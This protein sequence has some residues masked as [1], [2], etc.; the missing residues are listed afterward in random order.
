MRG[1]LF[2]SATVSCFPRRFKNYRPARAACISA[3]H[4]NQAGKKTSYFPRPLPKNMVLHHAQ[5][6]D[7]WL[8][9]Y[10]VDLSNS[11]PAGGLPDRKTFTVFLLNGGIHR[12]ITT[13]DLAIYCISVPDWH[14]VMTIYLLTGYAILAQ[15]NYHRARTL[16]QSGTSKR[17]RLCHIGIAKKHY[18][19]IHI[20]TR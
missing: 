10:P 20:G 7:T 18:Q 3:V 15:C 14:S 12:P 8:N 9:C 2:K 19:T 1:D 13:N 17:L 6:A 16:C 4:W 11:N 5:C